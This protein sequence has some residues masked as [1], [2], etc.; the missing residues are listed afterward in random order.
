MPTLYLKDQR[1]SMSQDLLGIT[2]FGIT[3]IDLVF[4]QLSV[5]FLMAI[6][7]LFI[8]SGAMSFM[9]W[10]DW[11]VC[12]GDRPVGYLHIECHPSFSILH[13]LHVEPQYAQNHLATRLIAQLSS[14]FSLPLYLIC[15]PSERQLYRSLGFRE[16]PELEDLPLVL[17]ILSR[18]A[19]TVLA[20]TAIPVL[21]APIS[22]RPVAKTFAPPKPSPAWHQKP[23]L[24][25][26]G[27]LLLLGL[28]L[29][30]PWGIPLIA[31]KPTPPPQAVNAKKDSPGEVILPIDRDGK[32]QGR[33]SGWAM[34]NLAIAPDNE[35][36]ISAHE[37]GHLRVWNGR[38]RNLLK[39]MQLTVGEPRALVASGDNQTV[40]ASTTDGLI[41]RFNYRQG[42]TVDS[43]QP[44]S[45]GPIQSLAIDTK[46]RILAT[47][48]SKSNLVRLWDLK[49]GKRL[50]SVS[51]RHEVFS[52]AISPDGEK[53][54]VGTLS[55]VEIWSVK[56]RQQIGAIAAH[57]Q[58]V[59]GLTLSGDG[60][61]L[62]SG[63]T[64]Q[65]NKLTEVWTVKAWNL[66]NFQQ[67]QRTEGYSTSINALGISP[68]GKHV[69]IN[70][71][72]N[73][74][75]WDWRSNQMN[76]FNADLSFDTVMSPKG[77]WIASTANDRMRIRVIPLKDMN[78]SSVVKR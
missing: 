13:S 31:S 1:R 21:T 34:R 45:P 47:A 16:N 66:R 44:G 41:Q 43:L 78:Q 39:T 70:D 17:G 28:Y 6:G 23:G 52:L 64:D 27:L 71:C 58:A 29:A 37:D 57:D 35:T 42:V 36:L 63:G 11:V 10:R 54:Y 12:D 18:P 26:G 8:I 25:L 59:E 40:I 32:P 62:F 50:G 22:P 73:T 38:S 9:W 72:C 33:V 69:V 19:Q 77:D 65:V 67:L 61:T 74:Y 24:W 30:S 3:I 68:D 75:F 56:G 51:S 4:V 76:S 55:I 7:G 49:T 20:M 60:E 5:F 48:G 2:W 14:K 53:V 15:T 46:G